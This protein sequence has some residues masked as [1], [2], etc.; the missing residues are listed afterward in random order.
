MTGREITGE[1]TGGKSPMGNHPGKLPRGTYRGEFTGGKSPGEITGGTYR[2]VGN[3]LLRSKW[4]QPWDQCP[5]YK[6]L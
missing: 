3:H 4:S 6:S 1:I 5:E 2:W